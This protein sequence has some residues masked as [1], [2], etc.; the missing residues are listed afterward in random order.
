MD[1]EHQQ[2]DRNRDDAVAERLEPKGVALSLAG[3]RSEQTEHLLLHNPKSTCRFTLLNGSSEILAEH[4]PGGQG[5]PLR[6]GGTHGRIPR[7]M[8]TKR[9]SGREHDLPSER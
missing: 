8:R 5:A 7:A 1:F 6:H 2:G 9:W 4:H 3:R